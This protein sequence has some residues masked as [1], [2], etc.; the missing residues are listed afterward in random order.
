MVTVRVVWMAHGESV[1]SGL[2][3]YTLGPTTVVLMSVGVQLPATP[4]NDV[5]GN[6]VAVPFSQILAI[7]S[8]V[9]RICPVT[10]TQSVAGKKQL[11]VGVKV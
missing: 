6:A 11:K 9:G 10:V 5:N 7:G 8:N 4:F 2:K 1:V 3:V